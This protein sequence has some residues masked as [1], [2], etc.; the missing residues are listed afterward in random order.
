MRLE[1]DWAHGTRY[2][3]G[4]ADYSGSNDRFITYKRCQNLL[5]HFDVG[6]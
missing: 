5:K 4:R 1:A 3:N 6:T 2:G